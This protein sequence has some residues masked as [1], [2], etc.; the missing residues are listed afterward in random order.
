MARLTRRVNVCREVFRQV[1]GACKTLAAHV[2][3]VRTFT[4]M[5]AQVPSEITFAPKG[6]TTEQ[7]NKRTFARVL[8]DMQFKV[9]F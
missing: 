7:A 9:F 4:G 5:D 8:P 6:P 3:M 2:A 1:I